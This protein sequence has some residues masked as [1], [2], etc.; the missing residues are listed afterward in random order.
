MASRAGPGHI[1][2]PDSAIILCTR[3]P[4]QPAPR[5]PRPSRSKRMKKLTLDSDAVHAPTYAA[6]AF[7]QG[8]PKFQI[9]QESLDAQAAYQLV[10]DELA[11]DGNPVLN[12]ASFVTTWMEPQAH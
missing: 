2:V 11:L 9:P 6:R 7:S 10:H 5:R 3:P 1:G 4:T 8:V 12:L